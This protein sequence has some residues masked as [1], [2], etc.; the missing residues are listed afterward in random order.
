MILGIILAACILGMSILITILLVTGKEL[1][2][3]IRHTHKTIEGCGCQSNTTPGTK[4]DTQELQEAFNKQYAQKHQEFV[5]MDGVIA[6]VNK[7]M[8]IDVPDI[9]EGDK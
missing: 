4:D 6:E 5:N 8:G 7:V 1:N 3:H 2:I 9:N